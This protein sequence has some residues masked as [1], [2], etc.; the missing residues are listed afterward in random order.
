[1]KTMMN[2]RT[3][4]VS[5]GLLKHELTGTGVV[6]GRN[7]R[8]KVECVGDTAMTDGETIRVP[9]FAEDA[10]VSKKM[11][12][13]MRGY[14]DH[15]AS[16]VK[17][18]DFMALQK[19][20]V[21][22]AKRYPKDKVMKIKSMANGMEDVRIERH[23]IAEYPGSERNLRAT[24]RQ[25]TGEFLDAVAKY[26]AEHGCLP[27]ALGDKLEMADIGV[28]WLGREAYGGAEQMQAFEMLS[29]E[30]QDVVRDL[31]GKVEEIVA[32]AV[33]VAIP[34]GAKAWTEEVLDLAESVIHE[35]DP[36]TLE[37]E[38]EKEKEDGPGKGKGKGKSGGGE[39]GESESS[40][41][42]NN[43]DSEG[44][45]EG[46]GDGEGQREE[47]SGESGSERGSGEG[48]D[49]GEGR[50]AGSESAGEGS[51]E[52][53][54]GRSADGPDGGEDGESVRAAGTVLS[55]GDPGQPEFDRPSSEV[56][57]AVN[58]LLEGEKVRCS[59]YQEFGAIADRRYHRTGVDRPDLPLG[60]ERWYGDGFDQVMATLR[61]GRIADYESAKAKLGDATNVQRTKLRRALLSVGRR[62]WRGM[63]EEGRL[64]TKRLVSA[65]RGERNVYKVPRE[66]VKVNTAMILMVDQSGSM[67][68]NRK[69]YMAMET[70]ICL[71]E[72]MEG[73]GVSLEVRGFSNRRINKEAE[74]AFSKARE[75]GGSATARLE[76]L[77]TVIYKRFDEPLTAARPALG[78]LACLADGNNTD[79][80][81][82]RQAAM[83]LMERDEERK[84]ILTL[85]DGCPQ[86][87]AVGHQK[88]MKEVV[89]S[90]KD[91]PVEL[92]GIGIMD[93][94]VRSYY[95]KDAPVVRTP[96]DLTDKTLDVVWDALI[97]G[98]KKVGRR[99]A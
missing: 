7:G 91:G 45:G 3:G 29:E 21:R 77:D 9:A 86:A 62:G 31:V 81:F 20:M 75:A 39:A 43:D 69:R 63:R 80:A 87:R 93:D 34:I 60:A 4:K 98:A 35:W 66:R 41:D 15:E 48:S 17:H 95:G 47:G 57:E 16:H 71:A 92:L 49:D 32:D 2:A 68:E 26:E 22:W 24:A 83:D 12:A 55:D 13:V 5:G 94:T 50:K 99:A 73:T 42:D 85:S 11:A 74:K 38:E 8:V 25:V 19:A 78:A 46:E 64:D 59:S 67:W 84:I 28:T 70:A 90:L 44:E 37:E 18:T 54:E 82:I 51:G 27:K 30:V 52:P 10:E 79:G 89:A 61:H 1:M 33:G 96:A 23:H 40:S 58:R 76:P 72:A 14:L 65:V 6:L 97:G 88:H 53:E 56:T 36:R